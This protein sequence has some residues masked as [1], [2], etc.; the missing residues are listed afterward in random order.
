[1]DA[2]PRERQLAQNVPVK[3]SPARRTV[4]GV[5]TGRL[6]ASPVVAHLR[7]PRA[8]RS[9]TTTDAPMKVRMPTLTHHH[10]SDGRPRT[11]LRRPC[12]CAAVRSPQPPRSDV[13]GSS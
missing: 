13:C 7:C 4:T 11:W 8:C 1:M 9:P 2:E 5:S 3:V 6:Q 12:C 10:S